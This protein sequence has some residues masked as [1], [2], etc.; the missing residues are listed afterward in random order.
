MMDNPM[1]LTMS[2]AHTHCLAKRF[3][4]AKQDTPL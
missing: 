2:P 3:L 1:A 4:M